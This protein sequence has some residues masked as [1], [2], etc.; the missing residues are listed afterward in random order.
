[1]AE[2]T[3]IKRRGV[4]AAI[5][6][7]VVGAFV[8]GKTDVAVATSGT[9]NQGPLTLGSNNYYRPE[10]NT[11]NT[12]N[13]SSLA[14]TIEA[15]P[16]FANYLTVA[17][18]YV[19]AAD[20]RP[21][22]GSIDGLSG[23]AKGA[24]DGVGGYAEA[25]GY[26]VSGTGGFI[27]VYGSGSSYGTFGVSPS[28][29]VYGASG[30][31]VGGWFQGGSAALRLAP[32]A[33]AG[34]P[35]SGSHFTGDFVVDSTGKL[36]FCRAGGSP[37]TWIELTAPA[38]PAVPTFKTLPTP[39][40][41]VDTRSNLG[42]V[43]GSLAAATTSTFQ[44]TGRNGLSGNPALQIPDSAVT[45]VGNLTVL[46]GANISNGSFVTVWPGGPLPTVSNINVGPGGIVANSFVVGM[47]ANGGHGFV[48]VYN[49]QQCDY[50]LDVTGYYS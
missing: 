6:G 35:T 39:E 13:V 41:F 42:G 31:G 11:A 16:N 24:G 48:S 5:G 45:L 17:P 27:G 36:F 10:A 15:S 28:V 29:G 46:G 32:A 50:I 21:A 26:G 30:A 44:M 23:Y 1:M 3:K 20:A 19:F 34:A 43:Q 7:A 8:S 47:T 33:V 49:A 9:G 14:T 12:A 4:L 38:A 2:E 25:N 18:D 37:G 40:R 22:T